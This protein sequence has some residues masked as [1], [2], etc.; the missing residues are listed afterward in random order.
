[1]RITFIGEAGI[2][3]GGPCQE[4]FRLVINEMMMNNSFFQGPDHARMPLHN[5]T[6]L[7][8]SSFKVIGEIIALSIVHGGP[9]PQ[10]LSH[11]C[12]DY[13]SFGLNKVH[14]SLDDVHQFSIKEKINKVLELSTNCIRT[15]L[16]L[17]SS[18]LLSC[19]RTYMYNLYF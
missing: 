12:V 15:V 8:K 3:A 13:L 17:L 14:P 9:G 4:F 19:L 16:N 11:A 18:F 7:K 10:C 2:D 6:E 5:I 1:M